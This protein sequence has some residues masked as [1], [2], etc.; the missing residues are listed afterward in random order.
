MSDDGD[1]LAA[2]LRHRE[3][4]LHRARL[5]DRYARFGF[6]VDLSGGL[7]DD[8]VDAVLHEVSLADDSRKNRGRKKVVKQSRT[9]LDTSQ[10]L[11]HN[12]VL[13]VELVFSEKRGVASSRKNGNKAGVAQLV[14]RNLAKVE[15]ASSSLVSR[16]RLPGS[17]HMACKQPQL[18]VGFECCIGIAGVAQLVERNLAKVEVASSSLVSRSKFLGKQRFPF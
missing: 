1:T 7:F 14:E 8:L 13:A 9:P 16:S 12:L 11:L 10:P 15:V 18:Y 17:L 3:A 2:V 4:R 6:V 5:V